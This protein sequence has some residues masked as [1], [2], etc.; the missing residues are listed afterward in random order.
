M[1]VLSRLIAALAYAGAAFLF[2]LS[3][4][5]RG[6]LGAVQH[7]FTIVIPIATIALALVSR[8]GRIEVLA[9]GIVLLAGLTIGQQQFARAWDDCLGRGETV[10]LALLQYQQLHGDYPARLE[11][12]GAPPPCRCGFRTSILHYLGNERGFRLWM[13]NDITRVTATERTPFTAS[14]TDAARS[15][16]TPR[17]MP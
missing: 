11:D 6:E 15:D 7:L 14:G 2:G 1:L 13:T 5:Q 10:R 17:P 4:G 8:Q 12:L 3:L 9:T 16:T